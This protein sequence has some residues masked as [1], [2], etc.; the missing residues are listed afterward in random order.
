MKYNTLGVLFYF[1]ITIGLVACAVKERPIVN[2]NEPISQNFATD[3]LFDAINT[4]LDSNDCSIA[5]RLMESDSFFQSS[6]ERLKIIRCYENKNLDSAIIVALS[7]LPFIEGV[8]EINLQDNIDLYLFLSENYDKLDKFE[9]AL[10]FADKGLELTKIVTDETSNVTAFITEAKKLLKVKIRSELKLGRYKTATKDFDEYINMPDVTEYF[11]VESNIT[12]YASQTNDAKEDAEKAR[13]RSW[14]IALV[15]AIVIISFILFLYYK[16]LKSGQIK[17]VLK[18]KQLIADDLHD[19]LGAFFL[20]SKLYLK[21]LKKDEN[22]VVIAMHQ[23]IEEAYFTTSNLN[24]LVDP[25][26]SLEKFIIKFI[27]HFNEAFSNNI[28]SYQLEINEYQ[29]NNNLLKANIFR[30]AKELCTNSVKHSKATQTSLYLKVSEH[31]LLIN[32]EDNGIGINEDVI[33]KDAF[34]RTIRRRI[35]RINSKV[36]IDDV[37]V[38]KSNKENGTTISIDLAFPKKA[39]IFQLGLSKS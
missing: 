7:T 9:A 13:T 37:L 34:L 21:K 35:H 29:L 17:G 38:I 27:S 20:T 30:L 8:E 26:I 15:A 5:L 28:F 2:L 1:L 3:K 23:L 32:I 19:E 39:S 18:A 10:S 25:K 4:S 12:G 33:N 36:K 31:K 11:E 14:L 6:T 16:G 24:R 22:K